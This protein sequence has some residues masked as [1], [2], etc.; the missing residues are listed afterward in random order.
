MHIWAKNNDLSTGVVAILIEIEM[1]G[2]AT[3]GT[4]TSVSEYRW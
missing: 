1:Y 3:F 2:A 4:G